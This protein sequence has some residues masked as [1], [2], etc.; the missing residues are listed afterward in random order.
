MGSSDIQ[1]LGYLVLYQVLPGARS[2]SWGRSSQDEWGKCAQIAGYIS[3]QEPFSATTNS[4]GAL[5]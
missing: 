1:G 3:I 2:G 4:I 5:S